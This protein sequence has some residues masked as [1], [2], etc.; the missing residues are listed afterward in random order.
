MNG[1][2]SR[3]NINSRDRFSV[4]SNLFSDYLHHCYALHDWKKEKKI[5]KKIESAGS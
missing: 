2:T 1:S 4:T 5:V 3:D